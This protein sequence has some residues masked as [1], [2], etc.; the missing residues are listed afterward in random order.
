MD[1]PFR[2]EWPRHNQDRMMHDIYNMLFVGR[3]ALINA[4]TGTGK[5][6]A[7]ISA[8]MAFAYKN[9]M[10]IFFL[11]PKMSQH[12]I[13]IEV[14]K[15]INAKF[16]AGIGYTDIVGKKTMCINTDVNNIDGESFYK[17]CEKLVKAGNCAFY[18]KAKGQ[19][20]SERLEG[21]AANGH[22][23]LFEAAFNEG[24]CAYEIAARMAKE[25]NFIIADY[26]HIL[27]PYT[28]QAFLK[29]IAHNLQGS[30]VIWDEA[31]NILNAASSYLESHITTRSIAYAEKELASISSS[32]DLGYLSFVLDEMK[33]RL[34]KGKA[35]A[36]FSNSDMPA[37]LMRNIGGIAGDI[38]KAGLTY[39]EASHASRSSLI[40]ISRFMESL[41]NRNDSIAGIISLSGDNVRLSLSCLYPEASVAAFKDA[42]ANIFMSGTLLPLDMYARLFGMENAG[43]FNYSSP[44]PRENRVSFID[45][46]VSSK[47]ESRSIE[48]YKRIA[49]GIGRIR[50]ITKGNMAVFFPS[51]K[52]LD[53]VYRYMGTEVRHIQRQMMPSIAVEKLLSDFKK[54]EDSMLFGVMGGSLSEGIDYA[55]NVIKGIV[56][57]GIPLERP[58]LAL[59]AKTEYLNKKFEGKG[60]EYAYLVP[61]VIKAVQAAGRAIRSE[62][63]RAF[64]VFMD[65]RYNWRTYKSIIKNFVEIDSSDDYIGAIRLFMQ[66]GMQHIEKEGAAIFY[67]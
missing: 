58:N 5:T 9:D 60:V 61:G 44:F 39:I 59:T 1:F 17:S 43:M 30:I 24:V 22:N 40:H 8:A 66:K 36:F 25:S 38:E 55:N 19:G 37:E 15:G 48:E 10:D 41:I 65:K 14:L 7:A 3:S 45:T 50:A 51:F 28:R 12:S 21:A 63:D 35:E 13:A 67:T 2:F 27:S 29:R 53:S 26:A 4:P 16:G 47:Y 46:G 54:S 18:S 42:Y 34:L 64:I 11:T 49:I 20:I 57:V 23:A 52:M 62:K 32:I 31:H 6:D 33:E 56:I